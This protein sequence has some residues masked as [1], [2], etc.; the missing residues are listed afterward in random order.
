MASLLLSPSLDA[1]LKHLASHYQ[2]KM[3]EISERFKR[4]QL[5]ESVAEF[6]AELQ[7]LAKAY[8]FGTYLEN[9]IFD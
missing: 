3:I 6:V 8:T 9:T 4:N 5:K 2:P 7:I 1:I